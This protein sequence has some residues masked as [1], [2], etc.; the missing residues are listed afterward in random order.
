MGKLE[1]TT[2]PD[3]VII[4]ENY[5]NKKNFPYQRIVG[6]TYDDEDL[7]RYIIMVPDEI[8]NN[9][10]D[11]FSKIVDIKL[12]DISITHTKMDAIVS[13]YFEELGNK[14][15]KPSYTTQMIEK[16]FPETDPFLKHRKDL[17][18]MV[19]IASLVSLVGLYS[20]NAALVIGAMLV[21]PLLGPITA[22]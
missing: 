21:S 20:D 3:K 8:A 11:T 13:D 22:F 16:L 18:I 2:Y 5:L 10:V 9:V 4:I 19:V 6:K 14:V 1:V 12:R 7:F 15:E 17:L